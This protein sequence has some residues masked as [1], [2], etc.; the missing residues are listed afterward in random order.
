MKTLSLIGAALLALVMGPAVAADVEH[1]F[2]GTQ[3][4][5]LTRVPDLVAIVQAPA[6]G[7]QAPLAATQSAALV[8][9][10]SRLRIERVVPA[11]GP[12]TAEAAQ[13]PGPGQS[14]ARGIVS[15]PTAGR[16]GA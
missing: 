9:G 4:R 11:A 12:R 6:A 15:W 14:P 2:D 5:T 3:R 8:A 7:R 1:Y 16:C 13:A 10:D